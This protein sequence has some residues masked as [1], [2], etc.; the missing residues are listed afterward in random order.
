[1]AKTSLDY[2]DNCDFVI[3]NQTVTG[4]TTTLEYD[5]LCET[6]A[7]TTAVTY[8]KSTLWYLRLFF[9]YVFIYF[10]YEV[11]QWKGVLRK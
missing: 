3:V 8:Y 1:M 2:K 9:I 7:N 10:V 11:L 6:N 4:N 5:Y